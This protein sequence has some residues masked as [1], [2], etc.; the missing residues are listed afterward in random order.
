VLTDEKFD[1]YVSLPGRL[2][3]IE[4]LLANAVFVEPTEIPTLCRDPDDNQILATSAAGNAVCICS[5]D[6]DLLSL[7]T[8]GEIPIVQ[9]ARFIELF[10]VGKN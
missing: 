1:R 5:G 8:F 4:A 7:R 9:A 6:D 10:A 2:T 3:F